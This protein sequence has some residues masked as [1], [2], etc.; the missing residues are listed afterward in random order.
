MNSYKQ[1]YPFRLGTT[2]FIYPANYITNACRL[3]PLVDE[4]ELLLFESRQTSLPTEDEIRQLA[5]LAEEKAITYN[6]H[7]PVD[8]D[9]TD[10]DP[11]Q[12]QKAAQSFAQIIRLVSPLQPTTY[13]L[14]ITNA[15][16]DRKATAIAAWQNRAVT[17]VQELLTLSRVMPQQLSIETLDY[18]PQWLVPLVEKLDL[19]VC[20]DVGHVLLFGYDLN[21]VLADFQHRI[22]ILH[23][24]GVA[25]GKDHRSLIRL[26][27]PTRSTLIPFLKRFSGSVSLEVF[28]LE[29]L[30][31]SLADL[32]GMM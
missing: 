6:I 10:V 12:K 11:V 5:S 3:A 15:P 16:K 1:R 27:Q 19:A 21:K 7:L 29:R 2:S 23:L 32:A 17:G 8:L 30:N 31:S 24:H 28:S 26:D 9:L 4:L 25:D 14:H 18:P 13:T 22:S 20:V